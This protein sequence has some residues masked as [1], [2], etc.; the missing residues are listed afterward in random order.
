MGII[1]TYEGVVQVV[2]GLLIVGLFLGVSKLSSRTG[3][4]PIGDLVLASGWHYA[5]AGLL[6]GCTFLPFIRQYLVN[7]GLLSIVVVAGWHGFAIG[8]GLDLRLWKRIAWTSLALEMGQVV[9]IVVVALLAYELPEGKIVQLPFR[10]ALI[11]AI[12]GLCVV[13]GRRS[14]ERQDAELSV[15]GVDRFLTRMLALA[16]AGYSFSVLRQPHFFIDLSFAG[17]E[18]GIQVGG[19]L[20]VA[21]WSLVLGGGIG[22]IG[23]L[24]MRG[25]ESTFLFLI[26]SAILLLGC[27][28]A[29]HLGLEPIWV[30]ILAGAWVINSTLRRRDLSVVLGRG[31][32]VVKMVLYFFSGLLLGCGCIELGFE[33]GVFLWTF[34]LVVFLR[35]LA[36]WSSLWFLGGVLG[37][38]MLK[39]SKVTLAGLLDLDEWALAIAAI[40][41]GV[42]YDA[43]G[44][45]IFGAVLVGQ[46]VLRLAAL[47][48]DRAVPSLTLGSGGEKTTPRRT[49]VAAP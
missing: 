24:M 23:D 7:I 4:I 21:L 2:G 3:E 47:R 22:L 30:G 16:L 31:H 35:P 5:V 28:L 36:K 8:C 15:G 40:L 14:G 29:A 37:K 48:L 34:V 41:M 18:R 13:S 46:I 43:S 49:P 25:A 1:G 11:L 20:E 44:V 12:V 27:G 9:A 10:S 45:A 26:L 17:A 19:L 42:Q 33:Y 32:G 39:K 38:A 6:V